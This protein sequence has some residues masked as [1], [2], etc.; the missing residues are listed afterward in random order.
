[1]GQRI[2]LMTRH[3]RCVLP[4]I[5]EMAHF[6]LLGLSVLIREAAGGNG[7]GMLLGKAIT[8]EH[9]CPRS[10]PSPVDYSTYEEALGMLPFPICSPKCHF[11]FKEKRLTTRISPCR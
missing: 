1:M 5:E 2:T 6:T 4:S 7:E 9:E 10:L 3:G 11:N 8:F